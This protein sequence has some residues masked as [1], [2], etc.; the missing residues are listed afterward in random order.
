MHEKHAKSSGRSDAAVC[1]PGTAAGIAPAA[2]PGTA[3][4]R[5]AY[6]SVNLVCLSFCKQMIRTKIDPGAAVVRY[7]STFRHVLQQYHTAVHTACCC[8]RTGQPSTNC[9]IVVAR[10]PSEVR[11]VS[12][13]AK[14]PQQQFRVLLLCMHDFICPQKCWWVRVCCSVVIKRGCT[15][16]L[17]YTS[18]QDPLN[19]WT[20]ESKTR[21]KTSWHIDPILWGTS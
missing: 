2:L 8:S 14:L 12:K 1:I 10:D 13:S 9:C 19:S 4:V 5:S 21:K 18:D 11:C 20:S 6:S 15:I 3:V 16:Y 7:L 17:V